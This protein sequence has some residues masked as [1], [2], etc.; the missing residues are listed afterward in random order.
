MYTVPF[1]EILPSQKESINDMEINDN[2]FLET[3]KDIRSRIYALMRVSPETQEVIKQGANKKIDAELN[4][5]LVVYKG[6]TR[7]KVSSF[8]RLLI[9][10]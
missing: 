9:E 8:V 10:L 6:K 3:A 7:N 5:Y 4:T 1:R 2:Q